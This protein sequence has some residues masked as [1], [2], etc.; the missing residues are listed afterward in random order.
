MEPTYP[1]EKVI[2]TTFAKICINQPCQSVFCFYALSLATCKMPKEARSTIVKLKSYITEFKEEG[3]STDGKVLFCNRCQTN[4]NSNQRFLINQHISTA[5]HQ[6]GKKRHTGLHQTF[7]TQPIDNSR[8]AEFNTDLCR[9]LIGSDIP[10]WKVNNPALRQFLEKYTTH[11][12]PD[13]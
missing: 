7:L 13:Q 4:V 9:A 11:S 5:K 8:R 2:D 1:S 12:I 6:A 3:F 10:I